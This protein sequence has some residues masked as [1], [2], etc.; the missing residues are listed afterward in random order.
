MLSDAAEDLLAFTSFPPGHWKKIW[1]TDEIVNPLLGCA[2]S[3][4]LRPRLSSV[5]RAA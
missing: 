3:L 4:F 5:R 2:G 1:S